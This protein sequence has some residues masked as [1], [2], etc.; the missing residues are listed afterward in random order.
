MSRRDYENDVYYEIWRS[1]KDPD[2]INYDRVEGHYW[3][4]DPVEVAVRDE[5]RHQA[6][7]I[8]EEE[9]AHQ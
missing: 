3:N 5:I 8:I 1:G 2:A 4:G 7:P 6:P 9:D